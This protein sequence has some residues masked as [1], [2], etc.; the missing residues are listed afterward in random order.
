MRL[1]WRILVDFCLSVYGRQCTEADFV[2]VRAFN[3]FGSSPAS[4]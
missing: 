2:L 4:W 3:Q 1:E